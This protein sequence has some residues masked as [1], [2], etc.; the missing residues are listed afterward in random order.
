[1]SIDYINHNKKTWNAEAKSNGV[2]STPVTK[3]VIDQARKGNWGITL[4]TI[5]TIPQNW[6]PESLE[7]KKVLLL[8]GGGGQQAPVIA[9]AGADVYLFDLSE[10]QVSKDQALAIE[11]DLKIQTF[12]GNMTELN[13][14]EDNFFDIIVNPCSTCFIP[15][16]KPFWEG[17]YRILKHG[18]QMMSG[19]VNPVWYASDRVKFETTGEFHIQNQIPAK[20]EDYENDHWEYAHSLEDLIRGQTRCGFKIIDFIEDTWGDDKLDRYLSLFFVT[21]STKF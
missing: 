5:R 6:F 1:M 18:G 11:H 16:V 21:L 15:D 12:V 4:A 10:E 14:F 17:C 7:N 9:A 20:F 13:I 19:S 8:A 2:W 3:E